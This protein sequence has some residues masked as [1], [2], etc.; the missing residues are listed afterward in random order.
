MVREVREWSGILSAL[1]D[2]GNFE[3]GWCLGTNGSRFF[4]C[5]S[6][7]GSDDG[8][9]KLTYLKAP[10]DFVPGYWYHVAGTYDG[11][12]QKLYVDGKLVATSLEQSG[13]INY[14]GKGVFVMGAYQDDDELYPLA[15]SLQEVSLYPAALRAEQIREGFELSR[16]LF[17]ASEE[18]PSEAGWPTY[19]HDNERSG[20]TPE[21]LELPLVESWKYKARQMPRPG[22][23][24]RWATT[25]RPPRRP[26][27]S[28]TI[29]ARISL[30]YG[31]SRTCQAVRPRRAAPMTSAMSPTRM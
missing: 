4:F 1:Q 9:G 13:A 11:A 16:K 15:G 18:E 17:P 26:T 24:A 31:P 3:K 22:W 25:P 21:S 27:I 30:P 20:I 23:S 2:N 14:P 5:L 10:T 29:N 6:S 19:L 12:S 28:V 8:D 7:S